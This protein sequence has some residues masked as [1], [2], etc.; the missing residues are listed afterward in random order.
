MVVV[1]CLVT[2][3]EPGAQGVG[4][5]WDDQAT[6]DAD[7]RQRLAD[8]LVEVGAISPEEVIDDAVAATRDAVAFQV[9]RSTLDRF[10]SLRE[11]LREAAAAYR[12]GDLEQAETGANQVAR[13][14]EADPLA[15]GSTR[16]AWSAHLLRAQVA[17]TRADDAAMEAALR[18][19]VA[20]DPDAQISTRQHP[21]SFA[22]EHRRVR[23]ESLAARESWP[24]LAVEL[25]ADPAVYVEVDGRPGLRPVPP[26]THFV[27]VRRP[28]R[29]PVAAA[30]STDAPFELPPSPVVVPDAAPKDRTLAEA[31]C[32]RLS[33]G[34]IVLARIRD[35]R[36]G[37]QGYACGRGFGPPW[38]E[39]PDSI[40]DGVRV[41]LG[42]SG[43]TFDR[44]EAQITGDAPWPVPRMVEPPP[45]RVDV[46]QPPP[47][48]WYRR[49]WVWV[50]VG[51][52]V[53]AAVVTGA[54]LGTRGSQRTIAVD[55]GTFT[56]PR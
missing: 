20:L 56:N 17:W 12:A 5:A 29:A 27:V 23:E 42:F 14:L 39:G 43:Q 34:H 48:P 38:Y 51:G 24:T 30:V 36:W 19:A 31:I 9:E 47:K 2:G 22:L 40:E 7:A 18:A 3:P 25:P 8:M 33:L 46:V 35:G 1:A 28:G 41:T 6:A 55:W 49:A 50:L 16:L 32:E 10:A 21:P 52:T 44:A 11:R 45:E 37:L 13:S 15:P 4:I 26:G 54:V 53:S